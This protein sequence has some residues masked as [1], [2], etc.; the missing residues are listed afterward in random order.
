MVSGH[1]SGAAQTKQGKRGGA[2]EERGQSCH[3]VEELH[4]L[5]IQGQ[6][7]RSKRM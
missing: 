2:C 4:I 1:Q 5:W 7:K 6:G 3:L